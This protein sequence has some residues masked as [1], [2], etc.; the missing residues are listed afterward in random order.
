MNSQDA[1]KAWIN[2]PQGVYSSNGALTTQCNIVLS[3]AMIIARYKDSKYQVRK[4]GP[5]MTTNKHIGMVRRA[6]PANLLVEVDECD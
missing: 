3:Y 1:V 4:R 5:S 6:I 2:N